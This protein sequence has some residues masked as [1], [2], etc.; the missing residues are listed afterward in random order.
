MPP[1]W[2]ALVAGGAQVS[3]VGEPLLDLNYGLFRSQVIIQFEFEE[4]PEPKGLL[5]AELRQITKKY[6]S[7]VKAAEAIGASEA[8]VRLNAQKRGKGKCYGKTH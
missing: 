5:P 6:G 3:E 8:F 1:V 7:Y 4:I 2:F